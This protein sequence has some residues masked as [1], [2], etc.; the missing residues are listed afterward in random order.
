MPGVTVGQFVSVFIA[1][2][3]AAHAV[4]VHQN[5]C[6]VGFRPTV[7][8]QS[9]DGVF[10]MGTVFLLLHHRRQAFEDIPLCL[11]QAMQLAHQRFWQC[12]GVIV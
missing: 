5:Q 8:K 4:A 6:I 1:R 9:L 11:W 2:Q 12:D 10:Q 7:P 3:P